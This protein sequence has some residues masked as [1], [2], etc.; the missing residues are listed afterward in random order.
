MAMIPVLNRGVPSMADNDGKDG[1]SGGGDFWG[2][3]FGSSPSSGNSSGSFFGGDSGPAVP[4]T[5]KSQSTG[6]WFD[7]GLFS[8]SSAGSSHQS[9]NTTLHSNNSGHVVAQTTR[10]GNTLH[11]SAVNGLGLTGRSLGTSQVHGDTIS[12]FDASGRPAGT[13][14][15]RAGGLV[16]T[17]DAHGNHTH[18]T[19]L[20]GG[21]SL[22][23]RSSHE[24]ARCHPGGYGGGGYTRSWTGSSSGDRSGLFAIVGIGLI[25]LVLWAL[26]ASTSP[27]RTYS[28]KELSRS[29][30]PAA[31][32]WAKKQL[33]RAGKA[34]KPKSPAN[35]QGMTKEQIQE[36][37][38]QLFT[39]PPDNS[40][41]P[42]SGS[43][44]SMTDEEIQRKA[45]EILADSATRRSGNTSANQA[46]PL[47][48]QPM[49]SEQQ[50]IA[51]DIL[52]DRATCDKN[53]N[54]SPRDY[55]EQLLSRNKQNKDSHLDE[56]AR[57]ALR[58]SISPRDY[59]EQLLSRNNQSSNSHLDE[60]A[61]AALRE[62][63]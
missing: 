35:N 44:Q 19:Q 59:A 57:A 3:F 21:G 33:Q 6:G 29:S 51:R 17:F 63:H 22:A 16:E 18:N 31:S 23:E 15:M 34:D 26:F 49:S 54:I 7:G 9:G 41:P 25:V 13:S 30:S 14:H 2:D 43:S 47:S 48:Q 56:V 40:K 1:K 27:H 58:Q 10:S 52:A 60:V 39:W 38:R 61:R 62:S 42:V 37:A 46:P 53:G 20:S 8:G 28:D 4:G 5:G 36:R 50:R 11:H 24:L 32:D 55:A 12:H 45:R